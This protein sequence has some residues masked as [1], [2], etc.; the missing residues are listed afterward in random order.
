MENAP[1]IAVSTCLL[2]EKVRYDG[3]HKHDR[4]ITGTVGQCMD[5]VPICP[6]VE[7]G[8]PTPREAMHL[9]GDP[10]APRLIASRSRTDLSDAML[11]WAE[12]RL[13]ELDKLPLCG[14]ILKI[15]SPSS[16]MRDITVIDPESDSRRK[17]SGIW[18]G[19][20]M[21]R[22]QLIPVEDEGRLHDPGL[23][24]NFFERVFVMKRWRDMVLAGSG[25]HGDLVRFHSIHKLLVMSHS[26]QA[27]RELGKLVAGKW[28]DA[29]QQRNAYAEKL[30]A[31]L[32]LRA[33]AKKHR[34]VLHHIMG[35]FKK[36]LSADEKRELLD[37]ID[38][39][40]EGNM[41]LIVPVTM[42]NHYVRKFSEPYLAEQ[43]YLNPH[44]LELKLRSYL[45]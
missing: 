6:E 26:V 4:Y 19:L 22:F 35:Y 31:A 42:L 10:S 28:P 9:E 27:Y 1:L 13:G 25:R 34:N 14:Y 39:A 2:G 23:R 29:P 24:E 20:F 7:C 11:N 37:L 41:P 44:P 36:Q 30:F 15:K 45:L 32:K 3:G 8:L 12:K 40:A 16:G 38:H 17:G 33:T 43:V 5:F 18:A 21:R